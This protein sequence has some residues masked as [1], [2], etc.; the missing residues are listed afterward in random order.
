MVSLIDILKSLVIGYVT[1]FIISIPLG[2]S[3]IESVNRTISKGFKEGFMVSIGAISADMSY[4]LLINCGLLSFLN[5]NKSFE[6]LFWLISGI[7][8]VFIGYKYIIDSTNKLHFVSNFNNST[9]FLY[10]YIITFFNPMTLTLWL[11]LSA[12]VMRVWYSMG[13]LYYYCFIISILAGMITWF[14]VLNLLALRGF[15]MLKKS[16]STN[17]SNFINY[18]IL[19]LGISFIIYSIIIFVNFL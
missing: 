5:K 17:I 12:T 2:P 15:K 6:I 19:I 4:L 8:L 13:Y 7:I 18:F 3:T 11:G 14:F 1:G 16:Y 10:G 9:S